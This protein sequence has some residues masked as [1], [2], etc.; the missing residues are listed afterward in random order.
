MRLPD[1]LLGEPRLLCKPDGRRALEN[2][3]VREFCSF[4]PASL[5]SVAISTAWIGKRS[6]EGHWWLSS[7]RSH[8]GFTSLT[9]RDLLLVLDFGGVM[10]AIC[11]EPALFLP[12]HGL[13]TPP[14]QPWLYVEHSDGTR[15]VIT[16]S[17]SSEPENT[18]ATAFDGS[19]VAVIPPPGVIDSELRIIRWLAGF[20]FDRFWLDPS[21]ESVLR[22][23]CAGGTT[24]GQ[25]LATCA[26]RM[27]VSPDIVRGNV[28]S[29]LWRGAISLRDMAAPLSDCS[30][31]TAA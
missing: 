12:A 26:P 11:R 13:P 6:Y 30:E 31:V 24:I 23:A 2:L 17:A 8:I 4:S 28:Y 27:D 19:G 9:E 5:T 3:S 16:R 10:R 29:L 14:V 15:A 22:D 20:R 21:Q 18:L 7:T 25:L 1:N